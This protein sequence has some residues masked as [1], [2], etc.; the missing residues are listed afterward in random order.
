MKEMDYRSG[1]YVLK[2]GREGG[3]QIGEGEEYKLFQLY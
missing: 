3:K 2:E 1:Y